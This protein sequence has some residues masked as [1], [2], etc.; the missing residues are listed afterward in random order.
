MNRKK[1][2]SSQKRVSSSNDGSS[3]TISSN[4]LEIPG[5][6]YDEVKKRYFKIQPNY[7]T[8]ANVL[9]NDVIKEL[10]HRQKIQKTRFK[11]EN[12]L[13]SVFKNELGATSELY[14]SFND[15]IISRL[16]VKS[17]IEF[18][19]L[20]GI[21]YMSVFNSEFN[22]SSAYVCLSYLDYHQHPFDVRVIKINKSLSELRT[23][24]V[25]FKSQDTIY[26]EKQSNTGAY[27]HDNH[28]LVTTRVNFNQSY[29]QI[30]KLTESSQPANT[31][32]E[33]QI[34]DLNVRNS[35][36]ST[37]LN[38]NEKQNYS[39]TKCALGYADCGQVR[40]I[41]D[42]HKRFHLNS[43]SSDVF[44]TK[45]HPYDTETLVYVGCR[46]KFILGN[47]LRVD[48]KRNQ[49]F[50]SKLKHESSVTSMI[51]HHEN[52]N[53][54]YSTDYSGLVSTRLWFLVYLF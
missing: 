52:N 28:Y 53:L 21:Q 20:K 37:S 34:I 40:D 45:F 11:I 29:V 5:F 30:I 18:D 17:K 27:I 49:S 23:E 39:L 1:G 38:S 32:I 8:Q 13:L 9:T 4:N 14:Q 24:R 22:S 2:K 7:A 50:T 42:S 31:L 51:F 44:C 43:L 36:W 46:N 25:S 12:I 16:D 15:Q 10:K 33:T 41:Y 26:E 35:F 6:Y 19:D 3:S 48:N 47:D 54:L